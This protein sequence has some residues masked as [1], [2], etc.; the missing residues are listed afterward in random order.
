MWENVGMRTTRALLAAWCALA[1][2]G[3]ADAAAEALPPSA[4]YDLVAQLPP[5]ARAPVAGGP[6]RADGEAPGEPTAQVERFWEP[7]APGSGWLEVEYTVDPR[8]EARIREVLERGRVA[9]GHV[10]VLD[11]SDGRVL[12]YVSTDPVRFPAVKAYPT[13]SLMK[14]VTAAAVLRHAPAAAGRDCRYSGSPY[15]LRAR[16]FSPPYLGENVDSFWRSLA[17][18]NNQCFAR[19]AVG[20]V[21]APNLIA[22]MKRAG[23]FERPAAGH[24]PGRIDPI[25]TPLGLGELGSGLSGSFITPLAA[26]RL[27]ALLAEGALVRPRWIRQVRDDR[28]HS[29]RLPAFDATTGVWPRPLVDELRGLMVGVTTRGTARSAFRD[30]RGHSLLGGVQVAGKTGSLN[31]PNPPGRYEWFI[32]VAPAEAPRIAIAAVV[33]NGAQWWSSAAQ[34]AARILREMFCPKGRCSGDAVEAWLPPIGQAGG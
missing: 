26:A 20:E 4:P 21:G 13:A 34:I 31:G 15:K 2:L 23:F 25:E 17:I 19:L 22:E 11:P 18:S 30:S 9:L 6:S 24:S 29:L 10:I 33:V 27:A 1:A 12:A 8:L 28:G 5:S 16:S 3:A 7:S 32:G 14:V